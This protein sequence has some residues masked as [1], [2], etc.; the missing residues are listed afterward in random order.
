MLTITNIP[1][2]VAS[3]TSQS[4]A[5]KFNEKLY[6]FC[7]PNTL[8]A[9]VSYKVGPSV[10]VDGN[11]LA[12]VTANVTIYYQS[13]GCRYAKTAVFQESFLLAFVS[14][15][16]NNIEVTGSE[17]VINASDYKCCKPHSATIDT[18]IAATIS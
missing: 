14:T 12:N 4:F 11:A 9:S 5:L 18:T 2:A 17:I 16:A 15:G 8:S 7:N 6:P 3:A 13:C 1:Q 10:V